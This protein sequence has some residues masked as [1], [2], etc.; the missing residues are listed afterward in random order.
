M[1]VYF[2]NDAGMQMDTFLKNEIPSSDGKWVIKVASAT[3][4]KDAPKKTSCLR[5]K[6]HSYI[7][8]A[9]SSNM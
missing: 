1:T 9:V 3:V 2:T 8:G 5:N 6:L 4:I 7:R